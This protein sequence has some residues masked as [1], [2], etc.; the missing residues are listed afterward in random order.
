MQ[1]PQELGERLHDGRGL[2]GHRRECLRYHGNDRMLPYR[3][4]DGEARST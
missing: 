3:V 1:H 2:R 4:S